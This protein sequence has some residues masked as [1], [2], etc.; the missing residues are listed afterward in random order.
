MA[1]DNMT[2]GRFRLEGIPPAPRGVPQIE[3]TFDIDA[4]GIMNVSAQDK[5]TGKEQRITITASTN[6]SKDEVDNMVQDAEKHAE[7]DR[8][9]REM[10]ELKNQSDSLAYSAEK[11]VT[12]LGE[13]VDSIQRER[14]ETLVK[15]LREATSQEDEERMRSLM[16][17]LQQE[18]YKVSQ[19]AYGDQQAQGQGEAGAQGGQQQGGKDSGVVDAEYTVE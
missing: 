8:R 6:L 9:R 3:V 12:D 11:T 7:E 17:E 13:Q 18:L 15:D 4:N 10:V 16:G 14:I 1:G 2:L 5:A 19:A